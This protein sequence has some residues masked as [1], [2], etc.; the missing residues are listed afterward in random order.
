MSAHAGN[1]LVRPGRKEAPQQGS[2]EHACAPS[3]YSS[4]LWG[5]GNDLKVVTLLKG[6]KKM[7]DTCNACMSASFFIAD[8][9]A[10]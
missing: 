9:I 6:T 4:T 3:P 8:L 2:V 10:A 1:P 7:A 5:K